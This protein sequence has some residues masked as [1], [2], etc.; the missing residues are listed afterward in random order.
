MAAELSPPSLPT[1]CMHSPLPR[2]LH[3]VGLGGTLRPTSVS[4]RALDAA[5]TA[6]AEAGATTTRLS[7][8]ELDLPPFDPTLS[9]ADHGSRV[10]RYLRAIRQ[11]DVLLLSDGTY[12]GTVTGVMKNALDYMEL[13]AKDTPPYLDGKVV[14]PIATSGGETD[15]V[16]TLNAL[17]HASLALRAL[18]V[19]RQ[20]FIPRAASVE[21]VGGL[22]EPWSHRLSALAQDAVQLGERVRARPTLTTLA[23][24]S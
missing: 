7:L 12:H 4:L 24:T 9:A 1:V 5:L 11:A 2:P 19:P 13:L 8:R 21:G 6:A 10:A 16:Q 20:V 3:V 23:P 14:G 18:I 17:T 15:G 22:P